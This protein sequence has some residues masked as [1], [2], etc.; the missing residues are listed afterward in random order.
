MFDSPDSSILLL[1]CE[2]SKFENQIFGNVFASKKLN[3]FE[4]IIPKLAYKHP[5]DPSHMPEHILSTLIGASIAVPI[6]NGELVLGTWQRVVL[7][8]FSGPK[9]REIIVSSK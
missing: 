9:S 4:E 2:I 8:E 7:L 6:E 5:H 3:A 1:D